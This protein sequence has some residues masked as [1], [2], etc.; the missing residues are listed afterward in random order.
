[1][2]VDLPRFAKRDLVDQPLQLLDA[3][4][5]GLFG[6]SCSNIISLGCCGEGDG[7]GCASGRRFP[8]GWRQSCSF[9]LGACL[10]R[11]A[12]EFA[13]PKLI[14]KNLNSPTGELLAAACRG[15]TLFVLLAA[16]NDQSG[17][18]RSMD[19]RCPPSFIDP[20]TTE[21][22]RDPVTLKETGHR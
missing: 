19:G 4:V 10:R 11:Q 7:C 3:L 20:I 17:E 9:P 5:F 8:S 2:A 22:M 18:E 12:R 15:R 1:M 16:A 14:F 13:P 21:I 6:Q